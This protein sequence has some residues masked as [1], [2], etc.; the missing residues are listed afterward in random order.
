MRPAVATLLAAISGLVVAAGPDNELGPSDAI[1]SQVRLYREVT[2]VE[3]ISLVAVLSQTRKEEA[4][5]TR[6]LGRTGLSL[7]ASAA[8]LR[9]VEVEGTY[10]LLPPDLAHELGI[11]QQ[12]AAALAWAMGLG[13]DQFEALLEGEVLLSQL[14]VTLQEHLMG[15]VTNMADD[16]VLAM[17]RW[18]GVRLR[19]DPMIELQ[20]VRPDGSAGLRREMK[21]VSQPV[22]PFD[23]RFE[24]LPEP[25][26]EAMVPR[27]DGP[28]AFG[29][30]IALSIGEF[31]DRGARLF[32]NRYFIERRLLDDLIFVSGSFDEKTFESVLQAL[33][34]VDAAAEVPDEQIVG[35]TD[36]L[37]EASL[38][39]L[40]RA[41]RSW[42]LG[43]REGAAYG[44]IDP[45][46]FATPF[47]GSFDSLRSL[48]P[49]VAEY[50]A[51]L[52]GS[53]LRS[54]SRVE[55][56]LSLQLVLDAGTVP[57]GMRG[58]VRMHR[59]LLYPIAQN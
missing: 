38:A 40:D 23:A 35:G 42:F 10:V 4:V 48:H 26:F 28:L 12:R 31:R 52:P 36:S 18:S 8:N 25:R 54:G 16:P 44:D 49:V 55:V 59:A 27:R 56:R 19:L 5:L 53:T 37:S 24:G 17:E 22:F 41:E 6:R 14:P 32:D 15:I 20:E 57:V 1:S 34:S 11:R 51:S 45:S 33:T 30:G 2:N 9:L 13:E 7:I 47:V 46:V 29:E 3:N 21:G 39:V 43:D 58:N 50:F